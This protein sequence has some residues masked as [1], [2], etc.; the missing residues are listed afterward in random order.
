MSPVF[1]KKNGTNILFL[2]RQFRACICGSF[3]FGCPILWKGFS[4][5]KHFFQKPTSEN[6][7]NML[8]PFAPLCRRIVVSQHRFWWIASCKM[9][10]NEISERSE[11]RQPVDACTWR[12]HVE[13]LSEWQCRLQAVPS[14]LPLKIMLGIGIFAAKILLAE[15]SSKNDAWN[16]IDYFVQAIEGADEFKSMENQMTKITRGLIKI[17]ITTN[18]S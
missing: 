8:G 6:Q 5:I 11:R 7:P 9:D 17:T 2:D 12:R 13:L 10:E 18:C 15:N 4:K 14:L 1:S 3:N 16:L